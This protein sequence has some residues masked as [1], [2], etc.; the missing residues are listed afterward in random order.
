MGR[1]NRSPA[2]L[3]QFIR[4]RKLV[5]V[6]HALEP[7]LSEV[8]LRASDLLLSFGCAIARHCAMRGADV[9]ASL[10]LRCPGGYGFVAGDVITLGDGLGDGVAWL[11]SGSFNA[12]KSASLSAKAPSCW[13]ARA[14]HIP[15]L[16]PAPIVSLCEALSSGEVVN[17]RMSCGFPKPC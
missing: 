9:L 5:L 17:V 1:S 14:H 2:E 16:V 8:E 10:A 7:F 15:S 12:F 4:R 6:R 13:S 3:P 11:T